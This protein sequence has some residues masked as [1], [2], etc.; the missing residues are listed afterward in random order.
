MNGGAAGVD[1][2]TMSGLEENLKEQPLPN[3]EPNV[4]K[5]RTFHHHRYY[6]WEYPSETEA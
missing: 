1:G 4:V 2:Q 6:G 3:L 5:Y